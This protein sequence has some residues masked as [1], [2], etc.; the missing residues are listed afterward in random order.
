MFVSWQSQPGRIASV[1]SL[2]AHDTRRDRVQ[3]RVVTPRRWGE[4]QSWVLSHPR[5]KSKHARSIVDSD[6][7]Q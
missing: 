6:H 3:F 4:M 1:Q 5:G 7:L 2:G